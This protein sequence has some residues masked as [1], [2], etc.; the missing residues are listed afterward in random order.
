ME[1]YNRLNNK[2]ISGLISNKRSTIG[3]KKGTN[4]ENGTQKWKASEQFQPSK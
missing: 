2:S 4:G 1:N 3:N